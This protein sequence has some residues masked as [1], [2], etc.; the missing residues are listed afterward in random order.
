MGQKFFAAL[1]ILLL[2][3]QQRRQG[4][5]SNGQALAWAARKA[6]GQVR[7]WL[8]ALS[9]YAAPAVTLVIFL[10]KRH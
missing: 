10:M 7:E 9:P 4:S 3:T 8:V 5:E 1:A 6:K 2:F